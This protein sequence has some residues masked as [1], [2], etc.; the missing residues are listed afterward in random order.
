MPKSLK[1]L[2]YLPFQASLCK[3][4]LHIL[5]CNIGIVISE[6]Y[7][8]I[9]WRYFLNDF[10]IDLKL[11]IINSQSMSSRETENHRI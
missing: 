4:N 9:K 8:N 6:N 7:Y 1:E 2:V 5:K 11:G 3:E 10:I